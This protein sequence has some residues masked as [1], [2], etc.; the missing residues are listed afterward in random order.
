M[1]HALQEAHR[2]LKPQGQLIDI[3]PGPSH[4]RVGIL[5]RRR[6]RLVGVM[7]ES[8]QPDRAANA[9]IRVALGK[10]LFRREAYAKVDLWRHFD[11]LADFG[12]FLQEFTRLGADLPPHDWLEQRLKTSLA[13]MPSTAKIVIRGPLELRRLRKRG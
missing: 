3:R 7:Q 10:G 6:W 4:R 5:N 13:G 12:D 9:A 2:V 1:V 8:L 11:T